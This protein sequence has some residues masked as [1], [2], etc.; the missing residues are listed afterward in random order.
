MGADSGGTEAPV[1]GSYTAE[2]ISGRYMMGLAGGAGVVGDRAAGFIQQS[3]VVA[4]AS[5]GDV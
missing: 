4:V 3:V 1:R 2:V 5:G